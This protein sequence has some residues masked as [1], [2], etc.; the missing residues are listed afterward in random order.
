MAFGQALEADT[1]PTAHCNKDK[2]RIIQVVIP[3]KDFTYSFA[4]K[5]RLTRFSHSGHQIELFKQPP[6]SKLAK[7]SFAL[8]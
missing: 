8:K 3:R 5:D 7:G 4:E 2:G 1:A 6:S